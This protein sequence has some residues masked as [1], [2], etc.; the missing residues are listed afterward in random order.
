MTFWE[1]TSTGLTSLDADEACPLCGHVKMDDDHR[2]QCTGPHEF[3][4]DDVV[5]LSGLASN[6]QRA[7][8]GRWINKYIDSFLPS[9]IVKNF[10]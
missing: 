10:S 3:S 6:G 5:I 4:T 7:K 9:Q 8:P 2:L 1:Y